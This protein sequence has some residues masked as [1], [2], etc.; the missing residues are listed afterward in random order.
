MAPNYRP[1]VQ[2]QLPE[3]D[4]PRSQAQS[5]QLREAAHRVKARFPFPALKDRSIRAGLLL[6]LW[7]TTEKHFRYSLMELLLE[8]HPTATLPVF[9]LLHLLRYPRRR[10]W[11]RNW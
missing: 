4:R 7:R 11:R 6:A 2:A 5:N 10:L 1:Q 3:P 9:R 8:V